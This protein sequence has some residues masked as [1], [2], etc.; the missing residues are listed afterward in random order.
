[1]NSGLSVWF[2]E[3]SFEIERGVTMESFTTLVM[4]EEHTEKFI[5]YK[6]SMLPLGGKQS[7][8][9]LVF[10]TENKI[11]KFCICSRK[12]MKTEKCFR[13]SVKLSE[14]AQFPKSFVF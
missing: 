12:K 9:Y 6:L 7:S 3:V 8:Y 1:M 14:D 11:W 10:D 13:V 5:K 2:V 4:G